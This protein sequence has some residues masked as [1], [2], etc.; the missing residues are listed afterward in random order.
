MDRAKDTEMRTLEELARELPIGSPREGLSR[1][2]MA[3]WSH[4][5]LEKGVWL[6][7]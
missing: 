1:L 3:G 4:R 2:D 6:G 5:E 7:G